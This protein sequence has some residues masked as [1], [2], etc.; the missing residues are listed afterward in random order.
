MIGGA[1]TAWLVLA[2]LSAAHAVM[3]K[4]DPRSAVVWVFVSF[5]LPFRG[6]S[7]LGNGLPDLSVGTGP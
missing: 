2:G 6:H 4:R 7:L 3:Y 5:T 1:V